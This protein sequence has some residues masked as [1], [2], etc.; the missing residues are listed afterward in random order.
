MSNTDALARAI[1]TT[2]GP[3]VIDLTEVEYLGQAPV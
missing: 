3:L 1:E 2:D